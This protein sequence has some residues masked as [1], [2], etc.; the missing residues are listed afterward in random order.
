M[1]TY[2]DFLKLKLDLVS[3]S[4]L[5]VFGLPRHRFGASFQ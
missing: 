1:P 3:K 2:D 5:E 4:F